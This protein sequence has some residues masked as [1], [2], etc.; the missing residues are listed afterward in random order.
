MTSVNISSFFVKRSI[1]RMI[2]VGSDDLI[3][4]SEGVIIFLR[5]NLVV[6]HIFCNFALCK[7]K[8]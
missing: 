4:I 5:K 8:E 7:E 2:I 1:L 6:S 3:Q